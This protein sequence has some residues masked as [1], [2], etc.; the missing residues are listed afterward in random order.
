MEKKE[1]KKEETYHDRRMRQAAEKK[2][3]TQKKN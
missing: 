1:S 3:K 2:A